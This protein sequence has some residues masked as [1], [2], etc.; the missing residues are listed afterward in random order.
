MFPSN[1]LKVTYHLKIEYAYILHEWKLINYSLWRIFL[2]FSNSKID[3]STNGWKVKQKCTL[4]VLEF[5]LYDKS[6]DIEG[7]YIKR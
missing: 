5:Y 6:L 3:Y 2:R 4:S 7:G 1:F